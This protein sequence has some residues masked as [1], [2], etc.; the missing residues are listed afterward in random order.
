MDALKHYLR[1]KNIFPPHIS[2]PPAKRLKYALIIPVFNEPNLPETLLSLA[3]ADQPE[4]PVE[5]ILV[6]NSSENTPASI[7]EQNRKTKKEVEELTSKP[8]F[9][10]KT[11]I[12]HKEDL[13]PDVMGAGYARKTGMDEAIHRFESIKRN[14][15]ILISLDADTKCDKNYFTTIEKTVNQNRK[16]NAGI[17]FFKHPIEGNEFSQD[18]YKAVTQYELFLRYYKQALH[19]CGFPFTFHTIGSAFFVKALAYVKQGGMSQRKAG[20][21]FYFLNKLFQLGNIQE[22][23]ETHVYP[24]PR[25]SDRVLFGT[26]PEIIKFTEQSEQDYLTYHPEFFS[27]LKQFFSM[28][29]RFYNNSDYSITNTIQKLPLF[30]QTF[31]MKNKGEE[32]IQ[33][34]LNNCKSPA[35][36]RKHFFLWFNGLKIIRL[37]H[38]AHETTFNKIPLFDA[39]KIMLEYRGFNNTQIDNYK[40]LLKYYRQIELN[41]PE[42][43]E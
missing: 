25:P 7:L 35:I 19:Y 37:I 18:V 11:H 5:I 21:D 16:L 27:G 13:S 8:E 31:L 26:G 12:I 32:N 4:D 15:G 36:F 17:I 43:I 6:I 24:S 20:E 2:E 28:I 42:R 22:I 10:I 23:T 40:E 30:I 33:R 38:E 3:N 29:D 41:H 9:P 14:N 39:S 1:K 34:I